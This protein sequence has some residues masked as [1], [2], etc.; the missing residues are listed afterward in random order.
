[1]QQNFLLQQQQP[2]QQFHP[3]NETIQEAS[4]RLLFMC[5]KWCKSLPSF[6]SL[7]LRDQIILLEESWSEI[8]LL[9]AL[10]WSLGMDVNPLLTAVDFS[11][12]KSNLRLISELIQKFK[13]LNADGAE[14]AFL[15]AIVL[16]KSGKFKLLLTQ[17][18]FFLTEI[19][20]G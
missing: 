1:M 10:Q 15:K 19:P 11:Q 14:F 20:C 5:I 9:C 6:A 13:M 7:P 16:F 17:T 3:A 2:Q 12:D 4:A 18:C 8:F